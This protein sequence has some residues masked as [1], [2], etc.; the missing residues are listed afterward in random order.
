MTKLYDT[1]LVLGLGAILIALSALAFR[2]AGLG[3]P[4]K[5]LWRGTYQRAYEQR[6]EAA[7]P[8]HK[9]ATEAWAA[10]R[11][12][13]LREP[14]R[15]AIAGYGDWLFSEEEFRE[16]DAP[17]ALLGALRKA[18]LALSAEGIHLL[19][20]IL[21]DKA[22]IHAMHLPR[23]RSAGFAQRYDRALAQIDA[24]GLPVVDLRS[25]LTLAQSVQQALPDAFPG[26]RTLAHRP[27]AARAL[28][29][30]P[31]SLTAI[32]AKTCGL[33]GKPEQAAVFELP[34]SA[35]MDLLDDA[36]D[37][38]RVALLGTSFSDRYQRDHQ[39]APNEGRLKKTRD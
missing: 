27:R 31:G 29:E 39:I 28:I 38:P 10:L 30:E 8:T 35:G 2:G 25:A 6:F 21:P 23:A 33:E 14:A 19:P 7:A 1:A 13:L 15:G 12:G 18:R 22:R 24:A 36:P 16:P 37:R 32:V 9:I 20:I 34:A 11:W 17:R 4:A 26:A 5:G 3:D